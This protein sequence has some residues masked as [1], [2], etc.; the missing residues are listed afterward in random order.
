MWQHLFQALHAA[1]REAYWW[2]WFVDGFL[3]GLF[4]GFVCVFGFFSLYPRGN[5]WGK[6]FGVDLQASYVSF[7]RAVCYV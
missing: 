6:D 3:F 1:A 7:F 5:S 4:E 2:V